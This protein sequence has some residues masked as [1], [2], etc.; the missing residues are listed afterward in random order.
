MMKTSKSIAYRKC[1]VKYCTNKSSV[2]SNELSYFTLPKD[3][4]RRAMWIENCIP[5]LADK[6]IQVKDVRICQ[7]HLENKMFL[8]VLTKNRLT[9]N[10]IPTLFNDDILAKR[11]NCDEADSTVDLSTPLACSSP[12]RSSSSLSFSSSTSSTQTPLQL[13]NATPKKLELRKQLRLAKD[14]IRTLENR[15]YLLD[16]L[17]SVESFLNNC[18]K[19]LSPNLILIIKSHLMQK[20]R[21]KGGYRYNNEMKQF[22]LTIYFWVQRFII[23]LKQ[24]FLCQ[25]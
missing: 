3:S 4:E 5:E 16:H 10:A 2:D 23:L 13:S 19:F 11:A 12:D 22:A 17:D 21:K 15:L 18:E 9:D 6:N 20:E 24:H 25:Q 14:H 8:N 7:E 1:G